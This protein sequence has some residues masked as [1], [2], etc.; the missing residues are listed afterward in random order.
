LRSRAITAPVAPP[1]TRFDTHGLQGDIERQ[2]IPEGR[3]IDD[4][5]GLRRNHAA[6]TP[7]GGASRH[8]GNL[9]VVGKLQNLSD[10]FHVSGLHDKIGLRPEKRAGHDR[11]NV[12]DVMAVHFSLRR[13]VENSYVARDFS[14]FFCQFHGF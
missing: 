9:V 14:K 6:E 1:R 7:G 3:Q 2:N 8:H 11:R 13:L 10:L 5:P 4:D 12:A